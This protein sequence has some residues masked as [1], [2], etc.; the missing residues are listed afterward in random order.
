MKKIIYI[1]M[2]DTICDFSGAYKQA[3]SNNPRI[4]YPQSQVDFFRNLQ[5]LKNAIETVNQLR[6]S[7]HYDVYI[8]TAPSI[9]NPLCYMEKR[10]WI[11]QHFDLDLVKKLIISPDKSLFKGDYLI[12]DTTTKGQLTFEGKFIHFG[13][14]QYPDWKS[15]GAYFQI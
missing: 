12:D 11:E 1:D 13:S 4:P 5:P 3:I 7:E 8:L 10:I 15:V 6:H 2:D 14:D 9:K